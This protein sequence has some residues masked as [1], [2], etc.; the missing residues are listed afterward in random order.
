[1]IKKY[2]VQ[3]DDLGKPIEIVEVKEFTKL[4]ELRN[5]QEKCK[6]NKVVYEQRVS[7]NT[8]KLATEKQN[9][10]DRVDLLEKENKCLKSVISHILGYNELGEEEIKEI[11]GVE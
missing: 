1:M 3:Y 9:L 5:F 4:D 2:V 11:L 6:A 10:L 8:Q 7:E